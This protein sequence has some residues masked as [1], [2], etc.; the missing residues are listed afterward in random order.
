MVLYHLIHPEFFLFVDETGSNTNMKDDK[1]VGASTRKLDTN[2]GKY[3]NT[4]N[5]AYSSTRINKAVHKDCM[6]CRGKNDVL[7]SKAGS[8]LM[9]AKGLLKKVSSLESSLSLVN[10]K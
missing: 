8:Y 10:L 6:L 9:A 2:T 5:S 3:E 7:R 1:S 4:E